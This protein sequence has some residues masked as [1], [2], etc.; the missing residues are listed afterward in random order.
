MGN[1]KTKRKEYENYYNNS[2]ERIRTLATLHAK[3]LTLKQNQ[4]IFQ[5][6][7]GNFNFKKWNL[8]VKYFIENVIKNDPPSRNFLS[9]TDKFESEERLL[10]TEDIIFE[11]GHQKGLELLEQDN[12]YQDAD[13][14]TGEEYEQYCIEI[15]ENLGWKARKTPG[16]GDQGVDIIAEQK[17]YVLAIQCKRYS[18]PVGNKAVQEVIAGKSFINANLAVVVSNNS[19]TNS[20]RQLAETTNVVLLHH[21]QLEAVNNF[22]ETES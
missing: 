9:S 4:L 15:L 1:K 11:V 6:D 10:K 2:L 21:T 3:T 5:D 8:E 14:M 17:D 12:D 19:F 16:S 18:K 7:Y 22:F 13:S 20:A